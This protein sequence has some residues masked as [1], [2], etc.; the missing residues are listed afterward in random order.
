MA[1]ITIPTST[2]SVNDGFVAGNGG[3]YTWKQNPITSSI[4]V[5]QDPTTGGGYANLYGFPARAYMIFRGVTIPSGSTV[6]SAS[7]QFYAKNKNTNTM[8]AW[9]DKRTTISTPSSGFNIPKHNTDYYNISGTGGAGQFVTRTFGTTAQY[10]SF[11]VKA[12]MQA[13]VN[14]KGSLSNSDVYFQVGHSDWYTTV[15][16][17]KQASVTAATTF[18][19]TFE[20]GG[21]SPILTVD[22]TAPDNSSSS[23][24]SSPGPPQPKTTFKFT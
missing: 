14:L 20:G 3:G 8:Y 10:Q 2:G 9:L 12:F 22:Y 11:N 18:Y 13:L 7:M 19:W 15:F 4:Q 17:G 16:S 21:Q 1:T 6:N 5:L 24:S 23:S